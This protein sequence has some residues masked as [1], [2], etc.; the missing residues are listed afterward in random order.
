MTE[1]LGDSTNFDRVSILAS[2]DHKTN[3]IEFSD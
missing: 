3:I 2:K 1:G